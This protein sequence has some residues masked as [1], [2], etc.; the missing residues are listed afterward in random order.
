MNVSILSERRSRVRRLIALLSLYW[1]VAQGG[2]SQ[3]KQSAP[4][5]GHAQHQLV[6]DSAITLP[7]VQG[8]FDLMTVDLERQRLFVSAEDNHTVEV[9]DLKARKLLASIP[10]Q[11]EPK[12]V[13]YR[14]DENVLYVAT[15]KDGRVTGVDATTYN[16]KHTFQFKEKCNNL[17]YDPST[18]ELYVGVG[19]TFGSLGII[20]LRT[21]RITGEIVSRTE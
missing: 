18:R 19:N 13:V 4:A 8:G 9:V 21:H 15:G 7:R 3:Q 5:G 10:N 17:R 20:D 16:V 6:F 12:W 2:F 1:F 11:N 14:P